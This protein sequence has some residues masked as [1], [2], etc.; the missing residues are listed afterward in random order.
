MHPGPMN[1]GVEIDSEV[2]DGPAS[3]ILEQ[4]SNG[5]AVR[6]AVLYLLAGRDD[7]ASGTPSSVGQGL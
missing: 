6:M 2:A 4:V 5:V 3:V 7:T 1:R